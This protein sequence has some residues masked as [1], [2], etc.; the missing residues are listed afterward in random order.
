[1][2]RLFS[3]LLEGDESPWDEE[4]M[5]A[6]SEENHQ[7][8]EIRDDAGARR[9]PVGLPQLS[10]STSEWNAW[11]WRE[12][13]EEY[14]QGCWRDEISAMR[15]SLEETPKEGKEG[16]DPPTGYLGRKD[17]QDEGEEPEEPNKSISVDRFTLKLAGDELRTMEIP[18]KRWPTN[19]DSERPFT[20]WGSDEWKKDWERDPEELKRNPPAAP[21]RP[22]GHTEANTENGDEDDSRRFESN[23]I[24][25]VQTK[26]LRPSIEELAVIP[27]LKKTVMEPRVE[28][29][30]LSPAVQARTLQPRVEELKIEPVTQVKTMKPRVEELTVTPKIETK[31][32]ETRIDELKIEPKLQTKT[33]HPLVEELQL[34]PE[35]QTMTLRPKVEAL[36]V[37]PETQTKV[38]EP[39]VEELRLEPER[40]VKTLN[41]RVEE[42][43]LEPETEVKTLKPRVEALLVKPE[44]WTHVL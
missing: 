30:Y 16:D 25:Q 21:A 14:W 4:E 27:E 13:L 43:K 11:I 42:L 32:M 23:L 34:R 5:D 31:V 36:S 33:L 44:T 20:G 6:R 35:L 3:F 15:D 17:G 24:P 37:M 22:A 41:P 12:T 39:R 28:E 26:T 18:A 19:V 8:H 9:K 7:G 29:L 40:E 1:M 2:Q 38:L 10:D